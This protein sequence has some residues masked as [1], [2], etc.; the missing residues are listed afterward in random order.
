VVTN[1][2]DLFGRRFTLSGRPGTLF[3]LFTGVEEGGEVPSLWISAAMADRLLA[4]SGETVESLQA[5]V[6][7]L[8]FEDLYELPL[9]QSVAMQVEGTLVSGWPVQHVIGYIP[10][11]AGYEGCQDCLDRDMVVVMAQYDNPPGGPEGVFFPGANDNASSVAVM[12]EALRVMNDSDYQPFRSFLFVAYTGE[13]LDGGEPVSNPDANRFLQAKTGFARIFDIEAV[14]ILR[15]LGAG[16][17][18]RLEVSAG[19]SLRLAELFEEIAGEVGVDVYRSKETIDISLIYDEISAFQSG[20]EAPTVRL[21]WEG[22]EATSR[23]SEDTL[24]SISQ[25]NL[26]KAGETLALSLMILGRETQY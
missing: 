7:E 1:N 2:P 20:Q 8:P 13:G 14:I 3:N 24:A 10:G 18:D 4:G 9:E 16:T 15:G 25:T 11:T 17:G 21:F 22:W 19:G 6:D 26:E 5:I 23:R 12:L